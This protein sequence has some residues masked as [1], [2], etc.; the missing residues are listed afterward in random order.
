M[1]LF[2]DLFN[3]SPRDEP[4]DT[5][6][7]FNDTPPDPLDP[8]QD[9][10]PTLTAFSGKPPVKG[11]HKVLHLHF[12]GGSRGNPGPA[13]IGVTITTAPPAAKHV[14]E[15]GEFLGSHTNNVAEY[16]ALVRGLEAAKVLG[17]KKLH[18]KADSELIVRQ[19]NGIYRCKS[20]DLKPLYEKALT[21]MRQIGDVEVKHV[22]REDNSRAD[23]LANAAMDRTCKLEPLGPLP[24]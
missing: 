8:M 3:D 4:N 24:K 9:P 16:T 19:V 23:A 21:L 10:P 22:Y 14:Y 13:G 18:V 7:E 15:L 6:T 11:G 2:D 17:A 5:P 1:P 12:D 20:P